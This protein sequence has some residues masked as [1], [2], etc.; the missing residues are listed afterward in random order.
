MRVRFLPAQEWR[1]GRR[2]V[3]SCL[4]RNDGEGAGMTGRAA[5]RGFLPAQE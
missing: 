2:S 5:Q 4:R 1:R 3:G